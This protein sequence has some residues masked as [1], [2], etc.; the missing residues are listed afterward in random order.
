MVGD[1][2]PGLSKLSDVIRGVMVLA[3]LGRRSREC[4]CSDVDEGSSHAII[5]EAE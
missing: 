3:T 1:T 5:H 2:W 4:S